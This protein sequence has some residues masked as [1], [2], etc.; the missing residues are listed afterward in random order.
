MGGHERDPVADRQ[1][2]LG[3]HVRVLVRAVH[4]LGTEH[5]RVAVVHA[6]G[7]QAG[8]EHGVVRTHRDDGRL[9]EEALAERVTLL[10]VG[11]VHEDVAAGLEL[12]HRRVVRPGAGAPTADDVAADECVGC[13][14]A[15][16]GAVDEALA[17]GRVDLAHRMALVAHDATDLHAGRASPIGEPAG[18]V[19]VTATPEADADVDEH[20][21]DAGGGGRVDGGLAVDGD[22]HR[23]VELR[24]RPQPG[25][26]DGLVRQEQVVAEAGRRHAHH[27]TWRRTRERGVAV[28]GLSTGQ[29]GRLVRLDVGTQRGARPGGGHGRDVGVEGVEVGPQDRCGSLV[30]VG[31][32]SVPRIVV[33]A[34]PR[35][36]ADRA[37]RVASERSLGVG[38]GGSTGTLHNTRCRSGV[39]TEDESPR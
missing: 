24:H 38:P 28:R 1:R 17:S 26:V 6:E 5:L 20:S 35:S 29:L 19:D 10:R 22:G 2:R 30:Q 32:H 15:F 27:L 16:H 7:L 11:R 14:E 21:G 4:D 8:V 39:R 23:R 18:V 25:R 31:R 3:D 36:F 34:V 9:D 13:C 37:L 33:S 12:G